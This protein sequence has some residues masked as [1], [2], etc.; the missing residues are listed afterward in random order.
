M[1]DEEQNKKFQQYLEKDPHIW[2]MILNMKPSF[3]G[4]AFEFIKRATT[5]G[6]SIEDLSSW[7]ASFFQVG[8]IYG[9]YQ[10]VIPENLLVEHIEDGEEEE[11]DR[12][13]SNFFKNVGGLN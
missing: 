3:D 6:V 7:F 11:V 8:F 12:L 4:V 1:E 13:L 10:E 2:N 9:R 5:Q